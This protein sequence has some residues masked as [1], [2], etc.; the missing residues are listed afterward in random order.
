MKYKLPYIVLLASLLLSACKTMQTKQTNSKD[1]RNVASM[2]QPSASELNPQYTVFH[3][4]DKESTVLFKVYVPASLFSQSSNGGAFEARIKLKYQLYERGGDTRTLIDSSTL[5]F[6]FKHKASKRLA[7]KFPIKAKRGKQYSLHLIISDQDQKKA[8]ASFLDVDKRTIYSHQNFKCIN[9]ADTAVMV[10]QY[11]LPTDQFWLQYNQSAGNQLFISYYR[12]G[13]PL[14]PPPTMLSQPDYSLRP[15]SIWQIDFQEN[16][17]L[18]LP[19]EG[20]YFFQPDTTIDEGLALINFGEHFPDMKTAKDMIYPIRYLS[21]SDE[22]RRLFSKKSKK[23]AVDD[24]WLSVGKNNYDKARELIRIYYNRV[25]YANRF[26][27]SFTE[28]WR[29]DRGMI[30]VIYGPPQSIYK[31]D[32]GERWIY[33]GTHEKMPVNFAFEK[34]AH[35]FSDNH[36]IL[37]RGTQYAESWQEAVKTW[38]NG[39]PYTQKY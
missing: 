9:A 17:L 26:F 29:T 3:Q 33:K 19:H 1:A 10:R 6:S 18:G 20:I 7:A 23:E 38:R 34:H 2:Y 11:V 32:Y 35:P 8:R 39:K 16:M 12:P 28:G 14:A 31:N 21:N 22:Y 24:F 15:D 25:Q 37:R 13:Y 4:N 5:F 30:Y 27:T 36:Y